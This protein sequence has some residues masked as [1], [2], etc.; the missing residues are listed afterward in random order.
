MSTILPGMTLSLAAATALAMGLAAPA[1]AAGCGDQH[2][3]RAGDTLSRIARKCGT[4]VEALMQ[5]N[6]QIASPSALSIGWT[7]A[8]PGSE[9]QA[10][11]GDVAAIPRSEGAVTLEGW[12]VNGRRCAILATEDG[13]RYG[14]VS[15]ELSFVSGRAVAV[16]GRIIDDPTCT[17]PRTL[18]VTELS[19]AEL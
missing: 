19:T 10:A 5:A 18:L 4:S 16:E 13:E 8:V 15:P 17:G 1:A 12:I 9:P 11:A 3:I 6:P 14:V 2:T 7:L